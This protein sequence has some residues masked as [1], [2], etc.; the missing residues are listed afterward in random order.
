MDLI[1]QLKLILQI[2]ILDVPQNK[3]TFV[4]TGDGLVP[5]GNNPLP[6]PRLIQ[7]YDAIWCY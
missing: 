6:E 7:I 5:S 3:S 2:D 4:W 1:S